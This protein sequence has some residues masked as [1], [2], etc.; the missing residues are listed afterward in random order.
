MKA[1][2]RYLLADRRAGLA[3]SR[4]VC[5]SNRCVCSFCNC[6]LCCPRRLVVSSC[7]G[8]AEGLG[9]VAVGCLDTCQQ[10]TLQSVKA[11][12]Q[13]NHIR[14]RNALEHVLLFQRALQARAF[15]TLF[16]LC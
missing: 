9:Q 3:R 4:R 13:R 15:T 5:A 8:A 11:E 2:L 16:E 1:C 12:V 14:H 7:N 10:C 6:L